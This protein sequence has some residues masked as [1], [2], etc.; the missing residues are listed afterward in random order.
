[1]VNQYPKLDSEQMICD[2]REGAW[3]WATAMANH[4]RR[5]GD[6]VTIR[7]EWRET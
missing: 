5:G 6:K 1:M 7:N 4:V 3:H 2:T